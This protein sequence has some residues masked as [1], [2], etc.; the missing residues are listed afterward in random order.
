MRVDAAIRM[1]GTVCY[2]AG[3]LLG[4]WCLVSWFMGAAR[5]CGG[6]ELLV[7]IDLELYLLPLHGHFMLHVK[8]CP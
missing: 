3:W 7:Y 4:C 5:G 2:A 1:A 8:A 6:A